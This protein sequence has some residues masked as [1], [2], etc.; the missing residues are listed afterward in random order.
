VIARRTVTATG[1]GRQSWNLRLFGI[2][3]RGILRPNCRVKDHWSFLA[4]F[5]RRPLTVGAVAPSSARLARTVIRRCNLREAATVVELGAGTG[6]ITEQ[7]LARIGPQ[8]RFIAL[9]LDAGHAALLARRFPRAI[10][11]NESAEN[12]QAIVTRLGCDKVDCVISGLPWASMGQRKQEKLMAEV[13]A[14]L[15]PTGQFCG[16]GYLHAKW[17]SST[18]TFHRRLRETFPAMHISPV[19]WRNLPPAFAFSCPLSVR[20]NSSN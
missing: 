2:D 1:R 9:E 5:L 15:K 8:T 19:V 3:H 11:C 16:F 20:K 12:L 18:Q 13:L 4:G 7:I 10:V 17:Y 14:V 6:A